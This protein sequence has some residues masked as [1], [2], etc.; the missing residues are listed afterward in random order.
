MPSVP[1]LAQVTLRP[2]IGLVAAPLPDVRR[3]LFVPHVRLGDFVTSLPAIAALRR[4]YPRAWLAVAVASWVAPLARLSPAVDQV[5]VR[6]DRGE[7]ALGAERLEALLREVRPSVLLAPAATL[8][9]AWA[10]RAADVPVT[11]GPADRPYA[12]LFTRRL[13]RRAVAGRHQVE[14]ALA[15]AHLAGARPGPA[16][17]PLALPAEVE[18]GLAHWRAARGLPD[19]YVVIHAGHGGSSPAWPVGH[20]L[21]L[22]ALLDAEGVPVVLSIGPQD[23]AVWSALDEAELPIRRLPRMAAELPVLAGLLRRAAVLVGSTSGPIHLAAALR[24]PTLAFHP[25]GRQYGPDWCGPY[26]ENGFALVADA[27]RTQWWR[28]SRRQLSISLLEGISPA[29][30]LACVL[31]MVEGRAPRLG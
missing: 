24:T 25:P 30:A 14:V 5:V 3:L 23:R 31:E 17:F 16:E 1:R 28:R 13:E 11:I 2:D 22:A 15:Y 26:A 9:L 7:G 12:R 19:R 4:A 8:R 6:P 10:A 21:R 20:F 18:V 27:D 29:A